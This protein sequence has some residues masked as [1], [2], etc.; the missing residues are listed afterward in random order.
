MNEFELKRVECGEKM[1][2]CFMDDYVCK[3]RKGVTIPISKS[4]VNMPEQ[5]STI[6]EV[7]NIGCRT[8]MVASCVKLTK[9]KVIGNHASMQV[10]S[11]GDIIEK[12]DG[13]CKNLS[14]WSRG[15]WITSDA[16]SS[17]TRLMYDTIRELIQMINIWVCKARVAKWARDGDITSIDTNC[18][19]C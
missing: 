18:R 5:H 16:S 8:A 10:N 14:S 4:G 15:C 17:D 2:Q 6:G 9:M 12:D 1:G 19:I 13:K 11:S 3:T 7:S